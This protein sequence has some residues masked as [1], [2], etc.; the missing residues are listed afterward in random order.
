MEFRILGIHCS[1][2]S[3]PLQLFLP[4]LHPQGSQVGTFLLT[5]HGIFYIFHINFIWTF[6]IKLPLREKNTLYGYIQLVPQ[7]ILPI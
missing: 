2:C 5:S 3:H 4:I 6:A 1:S 7:L